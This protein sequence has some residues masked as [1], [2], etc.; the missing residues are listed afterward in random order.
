MRI[1]LTWLDEINHED[2]LILQKKPSLQCPPKSPID[3]VEACWSPTKLGPKMLVTI[4][5]G[6]QMVLFLTPL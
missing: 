1:Q 5:L 2:P 6:A 4:G 3:Q